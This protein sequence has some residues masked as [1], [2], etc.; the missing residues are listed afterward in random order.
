VVLPTPPF[1]EIA[2][3]ICKPHEIELLMID[4]YVY[5]DSDANSSQELE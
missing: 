1:P 5:M 2:I 4:M 3:F